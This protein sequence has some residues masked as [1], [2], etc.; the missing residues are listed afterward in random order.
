MCSFAFVHEVYPWCIPDIPKCVVISRGKWGFPMRWNGIACWLEVR[1]VPHHL[2][3]LKTASQSPMTLLHGK[4]SMGLHPFCTLS[5]YLLKFKTTTSHKPAKAPSTGSLHL[6]LSGS[7]EW[8]QKEKA[9]VSRGYPIPWSFSP[10]KSPN[11]HQLCCKPRM[12]LAKV[13]PLRIGC[14]SGFSVLSAENA[15]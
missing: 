12:L 3:Q 13:R 15:N 11:S 2:R 4:K 8:C 14:K 6:Q 7:G 9:K 1:I 10:C 5:G